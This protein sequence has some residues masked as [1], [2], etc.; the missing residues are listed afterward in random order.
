MERHDEQDVFALSDA[1]G[2]TGERLLLDL[3]SVPRALVG[4]RVMESTPVIV[5]DEMRY[6]LHLRKT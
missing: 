3:L 5:G 4:V 2:N 1:P 6:R